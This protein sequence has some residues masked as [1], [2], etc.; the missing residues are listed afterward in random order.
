M[1]VKIRLARTGRKKLARYRVVAA[2]SRA[3]RDGR[4][5]E[6]IGTYNPQTN[7]KE[8]SFNA[9]RVAYWLEQGAQP[10][11]TVRNLLKQ[12]RFSEKLEAI[13]KNLDPET[14]NLERRP[15]RKRQSKGSKK[16]KAE[17]T[18]S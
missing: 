16:K 3:K 15:E 4:F 9:E 12:D 2:D 6:V 17:S 1:P 13:G 10:S 11:E 7:P 8:F 5:L 14:L 18:E